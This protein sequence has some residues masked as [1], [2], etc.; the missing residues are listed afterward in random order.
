LKNEDTQKNL[1]AIKAMLT[2]HANSTFE[3]LETKEA[4]I[5]TNLLTI[6]I[7]GQQLEQPDEDEADKNKTQ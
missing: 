7:P 5:T 4:T 2:N 3:L 6:E 1:K